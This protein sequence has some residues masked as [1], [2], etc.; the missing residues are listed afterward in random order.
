[1][2]GEGGRGERAGGAPGAVKRKRSA[3]RGTDK[4]LRFY[5]FPCPVCGNL[6]RPLVAPGG[7]ARCPLCG[8]ELTRAIQGMAS[9]SRMSG[10]REGT[11]GF[12]TCGRCGGLTI[13]RRQRDSEEGELWSCTRCGGA[14]FL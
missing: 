7:A 4:G 5:N 13:A 12:A 6:V 8:E 3:L 10:V 1:M 11:I 14:V 9:V 2:T